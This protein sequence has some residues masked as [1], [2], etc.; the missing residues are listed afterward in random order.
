MGKY[1]NKMAPEALLLLAFDDFLVKTIHDVT[2]TPRLFR[3][4][5]YLVGGFERLTRSQKPECRW[6]A[7]HNYQPRKLSDTDLDFEY[8]PYEVTVLTDHEQ[9]LNKAKEYQKTSI[10]NEDSNAKEISMR[11]DDASAVSK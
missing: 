6:I 11:V 5:P 10:Q 7:Q 1:L 9:S 4:Q 3:E 2:V 8:S